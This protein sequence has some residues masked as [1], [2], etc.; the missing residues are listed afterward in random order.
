MD[1]DLKSIL[2]KDYATISFTLDCCLHLSSDTKFDFDYLN[3][4]G[5]ISKIVITF[6]D[7]RQPED[8]R[9]GR[10]ENCE[11]A[12]DSEAAFRFTKVYLSIAISPDIQEDEILDNNWEVIKNSCNKFL[13]VYR[14]VT[15]RYAI[16]QL[17]TRGA[18]PTARVTVSNENTKVRGVV[19]F[20]L[21]SNGCLS[22]LLP[23]RSDDEKNIIRSLLLKNSLEIEDIFLMSAYRLN[24]EGHKFECLTNLV[25]ALEAITYKIMD[26]IDKKNITINEKWKKKILKKTGNLYKKN[27]VLVSIIKSANLL[28]H[29][30]YATKIKTIK[31][32]IKDRNNYIH[33]QTKILSENI[34]N[35]LLLVE[36]AAKILQILK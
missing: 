34:E 19:H 36:E 14:F 22:T 9:F 25:I 23:E 8:H 3:D 20:N 5:S 17:T 31:N 1:E 15:K 33:R 28:N 12:T 35:Y 7:I 29:T 6:E 4:D 30:Q 11:I 13:D 18:L 32:L 26:S 24:Q 10:G 2:G 21:G 27:V 16:R